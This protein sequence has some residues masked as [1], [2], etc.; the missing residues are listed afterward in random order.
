[1]QLLQQT[2]AD[3]SEEQPTCNHGMITFVWLE[4]DLLNG[5]HFAGLQFINLLREHV[6]WR[7]GRVDTAG[8]DGNDA[9]SAIFEEVLRVVDDN[10][11]LVGLGD[12]G[13]DDVDY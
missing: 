6:C 9:V 2:G 12:V 3:K 13:E 10:A 1:M 11:G 5:F 8:L 7:C 4:S